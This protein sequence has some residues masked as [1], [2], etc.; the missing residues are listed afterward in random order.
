MRVSLSLSGIS[1][2]IMSSLGV[3]QGIRQCRSEDGRIEGNP[4]WIIEKFSQESVRIGRSSVLK[5]D[6]EF[7]CAQIRNSCFYKMKTT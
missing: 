5:H 1:I 2:F 4:G 6:L 3:M 7:S